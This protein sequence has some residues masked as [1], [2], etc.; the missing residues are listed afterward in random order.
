ML[1]GT[2]R[3]MSDAVHEWPL[4]KRVRDAR[5]EEPQKVVARRAGIGA[6]TLWQI[7][8]GRRRDAAAFSPPKPEIIA[9]LAR[10]LDIPVSE[11]LTLAGYNPEHHLDLAGEGVETQLA[12]KLARLGSEQKRAIEII[13]DSLLRER[14]YIEPTVPQSP[15]ETVDVAT[16]SAGEGIRFGVESHGET[17]EDGRV[18]P[19]RAGD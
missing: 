12:L 15:V 7:E 3:L 18:T 4:G 13:V 1:C 2:M 10:A 11:A 9:K 19:E 17:V 14:G 6:E 16:R 8:N 5:G